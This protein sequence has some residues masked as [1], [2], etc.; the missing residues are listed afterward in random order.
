VYKDEEFTQFLKAQKKKKRS[1]A[2]Q[3]KEN[4]LCT[5]DR[6][7]DVEKIRYGL[8]TSLRSSRGAHRRAQ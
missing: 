6:K 2:S 5:I 4:S 7:I 3:E 1:D 8:M